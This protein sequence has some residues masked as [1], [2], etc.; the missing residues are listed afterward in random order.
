M[1]C[2]LAAGA[3][4]AYPQRN[5]TLSLTIV[6]AG[7]VMGHDAQITAAR[8]TVTNSYDYGPV[9]RYVSPY[10]SQ[11]DIAVANLEVTLA[12]PPYKGYPEFSSPDALAI[13]LRDAGFDV[14]IQAN[15]HAL[16]RGE[17]GFVRTLS[18]LDS[19]DLLHT[20]T[21]ADARSRELDYPL[22]LEKRN[23]R[24]ALLNYT[25]GT[26]GLTIPEPFV[27]NRIDSL[28]IRDDLK[29]AALAKPDFTIVTIHW[30]NE[31]EREAN[32]MQ[33][34]LAK[35]LLANGA[36]AVIG[37]HPH[38]VQPVE[39]VHRIDSSLCTVVVY[40]LGI[41]VSNQRD[42]YRDGGILFELR[43]GK[44]GG[45][46]FIMNCSFMP[47]WVYR[48]DKPG[49]SSF[50]ILPVRLFEKNGD[51]LDLKEYDIYRLRR[52]AEDTRNL[53]IGIPE[54]GFF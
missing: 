23:I 50:C 19:L 38:V 46:T 36:D 18:V 7:D 12:G 35:F 53:L 3:I 26:N 32:E 1:I 40:S 51:S 43:L 6:F 47:A 29:K 28:Q 42:R 24:I 2:L 33:R 37:S 8:D 20:G 10:I 39:L 48:E 25:Y 41:F 52:F 11:A 9:F 14:M 54:N 21:F 17:A 15:N 34:L 30:G 27:I 49:K 5:D 22:I 31:Y 13:A 44:S 16:D 45:R 4:H